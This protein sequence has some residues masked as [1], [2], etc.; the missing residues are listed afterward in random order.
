M[1]SL[2]LS[3]LLLHPLPH[4]ATIALGKMLKT[5]GEEWRRLEEGAFKRRSRDRSGRW[6][7][8]GEEDGGGE[9][10]EE[11]ME[12]FGRGG[13]GR[14]RRRGAG[15]GSAG[16]EWRVQVES[17]VQ[18]QKRRNR[19]WKSR[20]RVLMRG[21]EAQSCWSWMT[22]W[23]RRR[24]RKEEGGR[25]TRRRRRPGHERGGGGLLLEAMDFEKEET[26]E[27]RVGGGDGT[28]TYLRLSRRVPCLSLTRRS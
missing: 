15:H 9:G 19:R 6:R 10:V 7:E 8:V 3:S 17:G 27:N 13:M 2:L 12:E 26:E 20:Q 22:R 5:S 11:V 4:H 14:G 24:R 21:G 18:E 23:R 25:W 28:I 16:G 1:P